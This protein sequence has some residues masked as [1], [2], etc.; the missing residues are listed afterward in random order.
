[1]AHSIISATHVPELVAHGNPVDVV[2]ADFWTPGSQGLLWRGFD[3][4]TKPFAPG[5]CAGN[6]LS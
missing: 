4:P 2:F 6:V 3:D 5:V 1:M